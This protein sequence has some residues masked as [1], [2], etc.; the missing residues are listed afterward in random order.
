MKL[1]AVDQ[2]QDFF[3]IS[4]VVPQHLVDV[5]LTTDWQSLSV[6]K[7]AGQEKWTRS[8]VVESAI[9]WI[10]QWHEAMRNLWPKLEQQLQIKLHDYSGTAF[11]LDPEGFTCP[12]H[13]DGEMP[14]SMQLNW[15]GHESLGTTF[16]YYK[17]QKTIRY[18]TVFAPNHGYV[19]INQAD[20]QGYRTLQWHG[21]LEPVPPGTFR[22]TSYTWINPI[23]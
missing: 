20:A 14:G 9:P 6:T 2:D 16:Y 8:L 17:N 23:K 11:W 1:Q 10:D 18:K 3:A 12:I 4:D 13:T 21:M 22:I 7:Q 19:M 15:L 5:I